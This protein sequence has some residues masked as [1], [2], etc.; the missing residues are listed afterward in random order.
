MHVGVRPL[1][2]LQW[3]PQA[4]GGHNWGQHLLLPALQHQERP[5]PRALGT[6]S[7]PRHH[8]GPQAALRPRLEW[9]STSSPARVAGCR[10]SPGAQRCKMSA[11]SNYQSHWDLTT[12]PDEQ[13]ASEHGRRQRA[14]AATYQV[15]KPCNG[16]QSNGKPCNTLLNATQRRKPCP[17]CG[18]THPRSTK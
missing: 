1:R 10:G 6:P 2:S 11:M 14:K 15:I 16:T 17:S 13:W 4:G 5:H 8:R 3:L 7:C 18:Y 12:I 9:I